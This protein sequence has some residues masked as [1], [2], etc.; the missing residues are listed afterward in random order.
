LPTYRLG[1]GDQT[2]RNIEVPDWDPY[3]SSVF[4]GNGDDDISVFGYDLV[5]SGGNGEDTVSAAGSG[6]LLEG[7]N[8]DDRLET[9]GRGD[10]L[11][12]GLGDD[13]LLSTGG[14]GTF[15]VGTVNTLTGGFGDDTFAPIGT[16]DLVVANDAGDGAV[17]SGDVVEG[18]F[19][20][21]TDYRAGDV[22]QTNATTRVASVGFDPTPIYD[23][24]ST[25]GHQH[26]AIGA[27]EYAVFQGDL[28]A[29]GRFTVADGGDDLLV[30]WDDSGFDSTI[31]QSG[32]VL[33]GFSDADGLLV[34]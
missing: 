21:V 31:F 22:L 15:E 8:G 26:L 18:M 32:V 1:N 10:T 7:G 20:V 6:N 30:L 4:G 3:G 27:G 9:N 13:F 19:D 33:A 5:L 16:K 28:T 12:G 23:H 2:F 14:G 34:A 11:L 17:S 25:P 29:P 24:V